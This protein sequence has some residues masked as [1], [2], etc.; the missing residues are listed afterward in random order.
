[1]IA[2]LAL[3]LSGCA[4]SRTDWG[5]RVGNYTYDQ[6]VL[7]LG[8]PDK[9]AKISDGTV[10]AEWLTYRGSRS[11]YYYSPYYY[12]PYP[13]SRFF[14]DP[15]YD[16]PTPDRFLRLTFSPDGLLRDWRRVVR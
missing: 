4:A 12:S 3:F 6:A 14:H 8:P 13:Y 1:M 16:P 10:V 2:A 7:E 5:T 9:A 11:G 15:F